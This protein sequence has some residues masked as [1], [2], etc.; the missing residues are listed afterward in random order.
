MMDERIMSDSGPMG[1][2]P[3]RSPAMAMAGVGA[4]AGGIAGPALAGAAM[5]QRA[6]ARPVLRVTNWWTGKYDTGAWSEAGVAGSA[7]GAAKVGARV[8]GMSAAAQLGRARAR[9][10]SAQRRAQARMSR[11]RTDYPSGVNAGLIV[12]FLLFLGLVGAVVTVV[13]MPR[14]FKGLWEVAFSQGGIVI[15]TGTPQDAS[16][17]PRLDP[18]IVVDAKALRDVPGLKDAIMGFVAGVNEGGVVSESSVNGQRNIVIDR[19][20]RPALPAASSQPAAPALAAGTVFVVRDPIS[21]EPK[22]DHAVS[23]RLAHLASAG[24]VLRGDGATPARG[25][26]SQANMNAEQDALAEL[27]SELGLAP[28]KSE[29]AGALLRRWL[30]KHAEVLM[31]AWI[32]RSEAGACET[33][34]VPRD[35]ASSEG[36]AN[37]VRALNEPV[38]GLP[39]TNDGA[40]EPL[41]PAMPAAPVP[42]SA[43]AAATPAGG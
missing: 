17:G 35:G 36:V 40:R 9:A 42:S 20:K 12:A 33:W 6:A 41:P 5:G 21:H 39:A 37:A 3:R 32:S 10:Q 28:F 15:D 18:H 16:A 29:E 4:G 14:V 38:V 27:R 30:D 23:Q 1:F 19:R 2:A 34:I 8:E 13:F 22:H 31:V 11:Y 24:Y 25:A 43:P 26:D 7:V